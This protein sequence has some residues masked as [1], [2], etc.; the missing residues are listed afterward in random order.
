MVGTRPPD[1]AVRAGP[2]QGLSE[3][4]ADRVVADFEP[5]S[6]SLYRHATPDHDL[7][8]AR[9]YC[10]P[11]AT[12]RSRRQPGNPATRRADA[13]VLGAG[14]TEE[15]ATGHLPMLADPAGV[16][17]AVGRLIGTTFR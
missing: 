5:G 15:L 9:V 10:T 12:R 11:H 16:G 14:W 8:A 2:T 7:P 17:R 4:V 6:V 13:R 1:R 3:A